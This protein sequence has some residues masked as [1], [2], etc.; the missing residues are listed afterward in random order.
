[1]VW[2]MACPSSPYAPTLKLYTILNFNSLK[3]IHE[4]NVIE[5]WLITKDH[6]HFK[7]VLILRISM[8]FRETCW[9]F[10]PLILLILQFVFR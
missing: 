2:A 10:P 9:V 3:E 1:M 7:L 4:L 5:D 6:S 8:I